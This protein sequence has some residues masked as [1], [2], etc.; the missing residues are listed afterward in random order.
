MED[1]R[2]RKPVFYAPAGGGDLLSAESFDPDAGVLRGVQI[3][4]RN[5]EG[6]TVRFVR[7]DAAYWRAEAITPEDRAAAGDGSPAIR[8]RWV[9]ENGV[10]EEIR[11]P[12]V[13]PAVGRGE[14]GARLSSRGVLRGPWAAYDHRPV[15]DGA[16]SPADGHVRQPAFDPRTP[17]FVQEPRDRRRTRRAKI[18]QVIWSRFSLMV[19]N[20]LLLVMALPFF[21]SRVPG[22]T[23]VSSLRAAALCIG[24]WGARAGDA[25]GQS[26]RR[27]RWAVWPARRWWPGCRW[28]C[29]CRWRRGS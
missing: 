19:L 11:Q 22:N 10:S 29:T 2:E 26:R 16:A 5:P 17:G 4:D 6:R 9:F 18:Q 24:A 14:A 28:P 21:L 15:A 25:S 13:T 3:H 8:M 7:A 1:E 20:A 12:G 23:L 27:S